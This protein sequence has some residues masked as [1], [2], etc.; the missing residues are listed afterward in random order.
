MRKIYLTLTSLYLLALPALGQGSLIPEYGYR[1]ATWLPDYPHIGAFDFSDTLFYLNDGDTIH[2]LG[3]QSGTA[4]K[5]FGEPEDYRDNFVSFLTLSPD[6]GT[7]WTGYTNYGSIDDRI[8]S[9]DVNS[10]IWTHRATFPGNWDLVFWGDSILVS[11]LNSSSWE[12][13]AAIFVLDTTGANAHRR[14]IEPGGYSAGM[15]VDG[16]QNLYY[17]TSY[18]LG[19]NALYRWG[20]DTL[21]KVIDDPQA[22][23][24]LLTDGVKLSDLPAGVYDCDVDEG[25]HLLFNMNLDGGLK[26]VC[27]W[28]GI[29]GDGQH[30]DTLATASGQWDW[31]GNIKSRGNIG[32]TDADHMLITYSFGQPLVKLTHVSTVGM[33]AKPAHA[34]S[35]YP[36]PTSGIIRLN[37]GSRE[38]MDLRIYNLQGTLVHA[39]TGIPSGAAIDISDQAA[40]SYIFQLT[41]GLGYSELMIQKF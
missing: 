34:F 2:M 18:A 11:G 36:N 39:A 21:G 35:A 12:A 25:G 13:P 9:I 41:D 1:V 15:A 23:F 32:L 26:V 24:L 30:I 16:Q 6:G 7:I 17:G 10:G 28:N 31:L 4:L 38:N 33:A 37:S 27:K 5:K 22:P 20:R 19:P 8:Y 40:G 3:I 29:E 14:I